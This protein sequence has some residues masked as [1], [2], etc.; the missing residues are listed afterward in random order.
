MRIT[1][2]G[3]AG[4]LGR[5]VVALLAGPPQGHELHPV[6]R[7]ACDITDPG[8]VRRCFTASRPQVV[9]HAAAYTDV[10]GCERE[11]ALAM[12]VN[13]E[14]T[15]H[16]AEAAA[17]IGARL[18]YISTDYVF[19]G[20]Q[21][22]PYTEE[23][24][25]HPLSAYGRSKLAGE[26]AVQQHRD[27]LIARTSWLYGRH[28]RHFI[29]AIV[30]RARRGE[31]LRVVDDQV[32]CPTW[33]RHLAQALAALLETRATGIVHVAGGG[34]CSWYQFA[35][36]ILEEAEASGLAPQAPIEPITSAE[37]GRPAPRPAYTVLSNCRLLQLGVPPLPEWREALRQFFAETA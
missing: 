10:D 20:S 9:I 21:R 17:A 13:G 32:G 24:L 15:R 4:M 3:A 28:G 35:R 2:T 33:T 8:A 25:P 1:V 27:S 30:E 34:S 19:D 6:S 36:A 23:D 26:R 22:Q 31:T 16:V 14:G 7:S 5:D 37:L 18:F 11:P 29:G 12:R